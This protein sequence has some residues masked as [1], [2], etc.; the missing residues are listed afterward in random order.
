MNY[1]QYRKD[2]LADAIDFIKENGNDYDEAFISVTGNDNGSYYCNRAKA[3]EAVEDAIWDDNIVMLLNSMG[4]QVDTYLSKN[5]PESLDVCI[6]C[7]MLSE[8]W[9]EALNEAYEEGEEDEYEDEE[10]ED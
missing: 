6:R 8:V 2:V 10:D 5:D 3:R 1:N 4:V 9:Q 7:A